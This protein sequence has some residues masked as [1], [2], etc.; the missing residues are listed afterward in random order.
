[1]TIGE[2]ECMGTA[3][4]EVRGWLGLPLGQQPSPQLNRRRLQGRSMVVSS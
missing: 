1:M 4:L 2:E 3:S